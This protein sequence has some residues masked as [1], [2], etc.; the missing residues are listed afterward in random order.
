MNN[1]KDFS[2]RN[3]ESPRESRMILVN[4]CFYGIPGAP[5]KSLIKLTDSNSYLSDP[6]SDTPPPPHSETSHVPRTMPEKV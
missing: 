4:T 6:H 5:I 1:G 2:G 3:L